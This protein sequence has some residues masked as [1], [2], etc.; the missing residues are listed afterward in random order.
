M[1]S[2]PSIRIN[3]G[4]ITKSIYI[5]IRDAEEFEFS[6][7]AKNMLIS[8]TSRRKIRAIYKKHV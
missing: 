3:Y 8:S 5:I 1:K 2:T 7:R 4:N 6:I